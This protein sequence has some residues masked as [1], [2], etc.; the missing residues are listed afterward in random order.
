M[1]IHRRVTT[2]PGGQS[3]PARRVA[4]QRLPC[5]VARL[6]HGAAQPAPGTDPGV[7]WRTPCLAAAAEAARLAWHGVGRS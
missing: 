7:L 2:L 1:S 5:G 3:V 4:P 6:D